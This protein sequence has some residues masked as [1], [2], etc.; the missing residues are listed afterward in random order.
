MNTL[1]VK[2]TELEGLVQEYIRRDVLWKPDILLIKKDAHLAVVKDYAYQPFLYRFFV[3]IVA[4]S[5]EIRVYQRLKGVAGVPTVYGRVDRYALVLSFVRGRN[6]AKCVPGELKDSFFRRLRES[7]D[8]IHSRGIVLC[9]L[10][11]AR[12]IMIDED[13]NPVLID[14]CTAFSRGRRLNFIRNFIFDIFYQDDLLGI[15]KLKVSLAPHLL[16]EDERQKLQNGLRF[17]RQAIW[18]RNVGRKILKKIGAI[19]GIHGRNHS[20]PSFRL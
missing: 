10:R 8:E 7:V 13:E 14:L 11:N 19:G 17:Q 6:A 18:L 20:G 5:R 12:N 4:N 15:A 1:D 16:T 3:G 2:R 9:D